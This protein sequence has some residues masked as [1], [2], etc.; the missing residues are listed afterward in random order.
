M[1]QA[2]IY[3]EWI[4]LKWL[5]IGLT[6]LFMLVGPYFRLSLEN[7]FRFAGKAH[8]WSIIAQKDINLLTD[9]RYQPLLAGV[10]LALFQFIPEMNKKSFKLTLHLPHPERLTV[11]KMLLF[12]AISLLIIFAASLSLTFGLLSASLPAAILFPWLYAVIPWFL[13]G[14]CSYLLIAWVCLEPSW[15]TRAVSILLSSALLSVFLK[16]EGS[17]DYW[18]FTPALVLLCITSLLFPFYSVFRFKEGVQD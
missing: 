9:L 2:F 18:Y 4:K 17:F 3:K 13:A 1:T 7:K 5:L 15:R 12:G 14:I 16:G 6:G 10:M 11:L 8:F